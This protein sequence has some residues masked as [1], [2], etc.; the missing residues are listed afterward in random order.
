MSLS[1]PVG[2]RIHIPEPIEV[3]MI[4]QTLAERNA[5]DSI[6]RYKGLFTYCVEDDTFYYLSSGVKN[7]NWKSIG[8]PN[9]IEILEEFSD[10]ANTL[11]SG[12]GLK[13]YLTEN[14]Y[15]KNQV[16]SL[17]EQQQV[18]THIQSITSGDV[19]KLKNIQED[20]SIRIEFNQPTTIWTVQHPAGKE[21][22]SYNSQGREIFGRKISVSSTI[23]TYGWSKPLTGFVKVN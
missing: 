2:F 16:N 20:I 19:Q 4:S 3:K 11:I 22:T 8:K 17:L 5:I 7:E 10:Q 13:I 14:Y 18:P 9:A 23:T 15:T 21:C 12:Y 1:Y 6:E